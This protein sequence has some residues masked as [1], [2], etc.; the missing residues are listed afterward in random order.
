[1]RCSKCGV[2]IQ[3]AKNSAA[4]AARHWRMPARN[5][6]PII[7]RPNAS[8]VIATWRWRHR[9]GRREAVPI[10]V[11]NAPAAENLEGE[12]RTVTRFTRGDAWTQTSTHVIAKRKV[13]N[14]IVKLHTLGASRWTEK[15][16]RWCASNCRAC[17]S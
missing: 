5:A 7:R 3:R 2:E 8:A 9:R 17:P 11:A 12:R 4:I 10:R 14:E 16:A 15:P 13:H 6:A 1:M